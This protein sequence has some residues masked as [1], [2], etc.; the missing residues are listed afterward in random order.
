MTARSLPNI[1]AILM[2]ATVVTGGGRVQAAPPADGLI[3]WLDA[4]EITDASIAKWPDKSGRGNHVLQDIEERRPTFTAQ[5]W[6]GH[7]A[8]HF[9]GDD[10]LFVASDQGENFNLYL[11]TS[12]TSYW[13]LYRYG[14]GFGN[15][16]KLEQGEFSHSGWIPYPGHAKV[17][18]VNVSPA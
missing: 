10:F 4:A 9:D 8:V 11:A 16:G 3:L 2:A 14:T 7:P 5:A 18:S 6:D 17:D 12:N 1:L 13:R 15:V